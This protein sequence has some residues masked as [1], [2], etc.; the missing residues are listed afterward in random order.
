MTLVNKCNENE[1]CQYLKTSKKGMKCARKATS[2]EKGE[3]SE[4]ERLAR[5]LVVLYKGSLITARKYQQLRNHERR[6]LLT[7]K[8]I[9][10]Y[11]KLMAVVNRRHQHKLSIKLEP[12]I[13]GLSRTVQSLLQLMA[14]FYY[15]LIPDEL[16]WF[17]LENTFKIAVGGDGAPM[18]MA[19]G[20]ESG[21]SFLVNVLNVTHRIASPKHNHLLFGGH[22]GEKNEAFLKK[23][24]Q[25][26]ENMTVIEGND[27]IIKG[28]KVSFSLELISCDQSFLAAIGGELPNSSTFPSSYANVSQT[29]V[30]V[31]DGSVGESESNRW[32]PWSFSKRESDVAY[33][34][35]F[36]SRN[37]SA[38]RSKIT[39]EIA[40]RKSRQEF[41]PPIGKYISKARIDPLHISNLAWQNWFKKCFGICVDRSEMKNV[42]KIPETD[43]HLKTLFDHLDT[44]R[45]KRVKKQLRKHITENGA[46][47]TLT[48]RLTGEESKTLSENCIRIME[49]LLTGCQESDF[50]VVVLI[51]VGIK[52]AEITSISL[53]IDIEEELIGELTTACHIYHCLYVL[54]LKASLCTW[55]IG[56]IVPFHTKDIYSR[57]GHGLGM[58]T[59][60]GRES[61]HKQI[62]SYL[63]H[64]PSTSAQGRWAIVSKHEYAEQFMLPLATGE[65]SYNRSKSDI[66]RNQVKLPSQD[67][68]SDEVKNLMELMFKSAADKTIHPDLRKYCK[69]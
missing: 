21:T 26:S 38:S 13:K 65:D 23:V 66:A 61:K 37:K 28:K 17:G 1:L 56:Y 49:S 2:G 24:E 69:I 57:F 64:T 45:L 54:F 14:S 33:I 31:M 36:K 27:F 18:P 4:K 46:D 48:L 11:K 34:N 6:T 60:Q 25:F 51:C 32:H 41:M 44:M 52:L 53:R 50:I 58:N 68:L 9:L 10:P 3:Q 16:S 39:K 63:K 62:K 67:K 30:D 7:A 29:E 15:T 40:S 19:E 43:C 5:S 59:M 55:T 22:C 42:K 8:P 20:E 12:M 47:K 35:D